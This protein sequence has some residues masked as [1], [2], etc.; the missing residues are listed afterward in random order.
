MSKFL[1]FL[2]SLDLKWL[3][4]L[5]LLLGAAPWPFEP[6]P[7]LVQKFLMFQAGTLSKPIDIFDVF[8]HGG[9]IALTLVKVCRVLYLRTRPEKTEEA[10]D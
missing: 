4:P 6:Q 2:D 1:T 8:W 3:L 10:D 5:A 7:H 9:P